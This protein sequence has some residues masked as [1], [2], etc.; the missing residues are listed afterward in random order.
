MLLPA[1]GEPARRGADAGR[2]GGAIHARSRALA[3]AAGAVASGRVAV[4]PGGDPGLPGGA[5]AARDARRGER[6]PGARLP[7][8]AAAAGFRLAL[9]G[10]PGR[11]RCRAL[12]EPLPRGRQAIADRQVLEACH[13]ARRQPLGAARERDVLEAAQELAEERAL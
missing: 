2:E 8:S 13:E 6:A 5:D 3:E 9:G 7:E 12:R 10:I 4:A 1:G 11:R